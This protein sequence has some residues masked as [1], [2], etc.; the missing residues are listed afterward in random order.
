MKE[1]Q[2]RLAIMILHGEMMDLIEMIGRIRSL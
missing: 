1:V 2:I